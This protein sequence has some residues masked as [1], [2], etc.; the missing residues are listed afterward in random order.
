MQGIFFWLKFVRHVFLIF[1]LEDERGSFLP[2][3]EV[4]QNFSW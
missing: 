3:D 2:Y 4:I 1:V